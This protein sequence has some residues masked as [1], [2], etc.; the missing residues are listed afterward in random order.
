MYTHVRVTRGND[1]AARVTALLQVRSFHHHTLYRNTCDNPSNMFFCS[2][3]DYLLVSMMDS[4]SI[5]I[6][7]HV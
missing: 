5:T 3:R 4:S 2:A 1:I 7:K 6:P